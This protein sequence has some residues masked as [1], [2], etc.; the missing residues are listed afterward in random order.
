MSFPLIVL[1]L[2]LVTIVSWLA[3]KGLI[4]WTL[5]RS[6]LD[7]PNARSSHSEPTPRGGGLAIV[8]I[9]IFGSLALLYQTNLG[10]SRIAVLVA[11]SSAIATISWMDDLRPLRSW[12]RFSV[13]GLAA[14]A[15][16]AV[17]GH[18]TTVE[19]PLLGTIDLGLAG[20]LLSWIWIVGLT[21]A[22]NFMDGIDGIAGSAAVIGGASWMLC[23][24]ALSMADT[25]LIGL[26]IAGASA[27]FLLHNWSPASIFMG[28][29]GS[30]FLGFMFATLPFVEFHT[31]SRAP[32]AA[33]LLV[34]PF[35]FD[36]AFTL[37][38]RIRRGENI[39][40][41][42]RTHMYQRLVIAGKSH[43]FV[44]LLYS[45]LFLI[46][47]FV[48]YAYLIFPGTVSS[49]VALLILVFQGPLLL[50]YVHGTERRA[51]N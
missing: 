12:Q 32:V 21:N 49:G 41:A 6:I 10:I 34:W 33:V 43:R 13:H 31:E 35:A 44:T 40:E 26:L 23:G 3:V 36:T 39:L 4:R 14:A 27:G 22:Y 11:A 1:L 42:H 16:I 45:V 29:V 18:W 24:F 51:T 5:Q 25:T 17:L 8:A 20:L 15:V 37:V 2:L 28:D 38:R 48:G 9:C 50:L 30:A 46:D 47:A 19:F 7:V